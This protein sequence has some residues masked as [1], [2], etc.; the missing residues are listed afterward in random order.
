MHVW[1][2][3]T[4]VQQFTVILQVTFEFHWHLL[5][6]WRIWCV[7][8][9]FSAE[10]QLWQWTRRSRTNN[11]WNIAAWVWNLSIRWSVFTSL[12]VY[13][14]Q[15]FW[16]WSTH[17]LL[18]A[19]HFK[20]A[21]TKYTNNSIKLIQKT[22]LHLLCLSISQLKCAIKSMSYLWFFLC[23]SQSL[24]WLLMESMNKSLGDWW[25]LIVHLWWAFICLSAYS[26]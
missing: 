10:W 14:F 3:C 9:G 11:R 13:K 23:Q 18:I 5:A 22:L 12:V 1:C 16:L 19:F 6:T 24:P 7:G 20:Q 2:S 26:L 21:L 17:L 4:F 15:C 25:R 8:G